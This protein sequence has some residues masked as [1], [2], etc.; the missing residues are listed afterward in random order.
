MILLLTISSTRPEGNKD[1]KVQVGIFQW[2]IFNIRN[3]ILYKVW[4]QICVK[5]KFNFAIKHN[6]NFLMTFFFTWL[7][8][9][10]C[11]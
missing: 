9:N 4:N 7:L 6:L 2:R 8:I 10:M 5:K 1:I 3:W 11:N